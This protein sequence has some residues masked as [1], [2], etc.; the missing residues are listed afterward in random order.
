MSGTCLKHA[1]FRQFSGLQQTQIILN[2]PFYGTKGFH[3]GVYQFLKRSP[4][5]AA[6]DHRINR[7][8]VQGAERIALSMGMVKIRV[9]DGLEI[10]SVAVD[11]EKIGSRPEMTDYRAIQSQVG[12]RGKRN[13]HLIPPF[14]RD[15]EI[16]SVNTLAVMVVRKSTIGCQEIL[17]K[18]IRFTGTRICICSRHWSSYLKL[19]VI[20]IDYR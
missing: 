3:A 2:G 19:C 13:F 8:A 20:N 10:A 16:I 4:A 12:L 14:N 6:N 18:P 5:D 11:N 7:P 15:Y 9:S 1:E 17:S